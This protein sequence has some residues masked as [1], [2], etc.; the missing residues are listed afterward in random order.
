MITWIGA[1]WI[2]IRKIKGFGEVWRKWMFEI[3]M[4]RPRDKFGPARGLRQG[5]PLLPF[6]FT[7]VVDELSKMVDRASEVQL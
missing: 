1:F 3:V 6:T 5:D 2:L 7:L 4:N